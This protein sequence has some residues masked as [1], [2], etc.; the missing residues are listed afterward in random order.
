MTATPENPLG[1]QPES[2]LRAEMHRGLG[3]LLQAADYAQESNAEIWLFALPILELK[4][5]GLTTPD[6]RW[7]LYKGYVEAVQGTANRPRPVRLPPQ[8]SAACFPEDA[9]FVLTAA[10]IAFARQARSR[11]DRQEPPQERG[12]AAHE[13]GGEAVAIPNY[14]SNCRELT[15]RGRL[16]KR[17]PQTATLQHP[18]LLAFQEQGWAHYTDD[19]L[20]PDPNRDSKERLHDAVQRLNSNQIHNL[21]RFHVV[22]GGTS[23]TWEPIEKAPRKRRKRRR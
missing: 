1:G 3:E 13:T 15:Y 14:D 22:G 9:R 17:L 8:T 4:A 12:A 6:L 5:A 10:G 16:V 11:R 19:P 23:I 2:E 18:I 7:L 20:P 21:L